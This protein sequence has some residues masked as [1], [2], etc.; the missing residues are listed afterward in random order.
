MG[1]KENEEEEEIKAEAKLGFGIRFGFS[2]NS[3][4]GYL[5]IGVQ[6]NR[7]GNYGGLRRGIRMRARRRGVEWVD[8]ICVIVY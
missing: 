5:E 3:G 8:G 4:F 6:R 1:Y 7:E 2:G